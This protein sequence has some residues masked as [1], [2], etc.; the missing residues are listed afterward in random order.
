[1][2]GAFK[3]TS[4]VETGGI[5]MKTCNGCG[6]SLAED[7]FYKR[8]MRKGKIGLQHRCK[9]C[10]HEL[11]RKYYK[12]HSVTK[13]KLKLTQ[14]EIDRLTAPGVCECCGSTER[15]CIDH[16]HATNK[17]RGLLCRECNMALG[18]L[19]EDQQIMINLSQ[20]LERALK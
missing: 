12:K 5:E 15:L 7:M 14:E 18:L 17:P 3:A 9:K 13:Y 4:V 19:G 10:S 2:V 11:S 1:M 6:L 16:C 8:T 20:Y